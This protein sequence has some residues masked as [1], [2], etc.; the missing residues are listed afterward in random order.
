M[1]DNNGYYSQNNNSDNDKVKLNDTLSQNNYTVSMDKEKSYPEYSFWAEQVSDNSYVGYYNRPNDNTEYS[2]R[3]EE[4]KAYAPKADAPKVKKAS[5]I[6]GFLTK[7]ACF[8]LLAGISFIAVQHVYDRFMPE[9]VN[10]ENSYVLGSTDNTSDKSDFKVAVT[11][12]AQVKL[13]PNHVIT[14]VVDATMPSIVSISSKSTQT[15]YWFG[16]EYEMEGSGSG[17]IVGKNDEELLIATNNHVVEGANAITVTFMDGKTSEAVI[18]GTDSAADLAVITVNLSKLDKDTQETIKIAKLGDSDNVKVGEMSI[19]IG[20][21]LGYGQ[22]VTVGYISALNREVEFSDNYTYKKMTLLQTDAAINPGNSGGALINLDGEVIG[23]NSVKYSSEL[24]E[25]MGYA[26]PITR[27]MPIINELMNR[28][29]LTANEQGYLGVGVIDVTESDSQKYNMPIGV[30]ISEVVKDSAADKAGIMVRDIV[31]KLDGVEI[32]SGTQLSEKISSIRKGTEV[33]IT[34]MR[35]TDGTYKEQKLKA[36][37][38]SR[39]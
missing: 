18:K 3:V 26:I 1:N 12:K 5:R 31:T 22:S 6:F 34:I 33:E 27:A 4:H 36:V 38:G 30:Y 7:A 15:D 8:G 13:S 39:E 32:T 24:V 37:L 25:G 10:N 16:N 35:N 19:A 29:I 9:K 23:I 14:E 17:I 21:A 11:D 28:E 20:N 2:G